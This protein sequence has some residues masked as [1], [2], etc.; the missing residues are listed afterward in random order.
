MLLETEI[1]FLH[2][3]DY[4]ELKNMCDELKKDSWNGADLKEQLVAH[5]VNHYRMYELATHEALLDDTVRSSCDIRL[6]RIDEIIHAH[7]ML[8]GVGKA[9]C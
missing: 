2:N 6:H 9:T 1:V 3:C 4:L 5:I 7:M 8:A